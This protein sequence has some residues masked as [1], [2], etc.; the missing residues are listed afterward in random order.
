MEVNELRV[1]ALGFLEAAHALR[2]NSGD[3]EKSASDMLDEV[4]KVFKEL[5]GIATTDKDKRQVEKS[6]LYISNAESLIKSALSKYR[7][8]ASGKLEIEKTLNKKR[9]E[10]SKKISARKTEAQKERV[11]RAVKMAKDAKEAKGE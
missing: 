3:Q 4:S 9:E 6:I 8:I 10:S 1:K 11:L 7:S 5:S 2:V